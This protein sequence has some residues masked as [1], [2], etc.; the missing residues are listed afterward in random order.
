MDI[1]FPFVFVVFVNVVHEW[2]WS[3]QQQFFLDYVFFKAEIIRVIIW[4]NDIVN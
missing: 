2:L 1:F 3:E 4:Q